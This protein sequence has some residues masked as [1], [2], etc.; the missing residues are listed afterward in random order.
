MYQS[1]PDRVCTVGPSL[2]RFQEVDVIAEATK[3]RGLS[4]K[5]TSL[6]R[7]VEKHERT[8]ADMQKSIAHLN[9]IVT[10]LRQRLSAVPVEPR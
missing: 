8:V 4:R 9:E 1:G 3:A 6:Q 10:T 2:T 7:K 5:V